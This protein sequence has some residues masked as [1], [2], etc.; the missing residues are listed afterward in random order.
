MRAR[1]AGPPHGASA[2]MPR[3]Q[4]R[5][6]ER[7]RSQEGGQC[8]RRI[9]RGGD[10]CERRDRQPA[11]AT[12]PCSR[13]SSSGREEERAEAAARDRCHAARSRDGTAAE[14]MENAVMR[15]RI[16]ER[17]RRG[18]RITACS[19]GRASRSKQ[20]WPSSRAPRGADVNGERAR[21]WPGWQRRRRARSPT[22]SAP[23]RPARAWRRRAR[24]RFRAQIRTT[25]ACSRGWARCTGDGPALHRSALSGRALSS[26]GERSLHTGEVVGSIPTAPTTES[27]ILRGFYFARGAEPLVTSQD[28]TKPE[29]DTS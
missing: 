2:T 14:R 5:T 3:A 7:G 11:A 1:R 24:R 29:H 20:S 9:R 26:A 18:G 23:C 22:A 27:P 6:D 28:P 13:A 21:R 17:R 4:L 8:P 10:P 16:A 19:K 15:E 12:R 25:I